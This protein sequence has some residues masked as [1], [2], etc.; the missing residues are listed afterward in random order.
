RYQHMINYLGG[1]SMKYRMKNEGRG[2]SIRSQMPANSGVRF[3][4]ISDQNRLTH[5]RYTSCLLP[6]GKTTAPVRTFR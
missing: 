4:R 2:G 1:R 6:G 3:G 5:H